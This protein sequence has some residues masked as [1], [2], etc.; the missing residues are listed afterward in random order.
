MKITTRLQLSTMMLLQYFI[1]GAWYVTMSTFL[2][3]TLHCTDV[4][5]GSAYGF[6]AL[7]FI[8][9][10]FFTGLVADRFF[11]SEKILGVLHIV[12]AGL[13]YMM[14]QST[15]FDV[16][17]WLLVIY[18]LL[19]APT[20]ALTSSVAM[21]QIANPEKDFPSIR[22]FGTGGWIV[23]GLLISGLSISEAS[24]EP[25]FLAAVA[26]LILGVF[27]FAL[28]KTPPKGKGEKASLGQMLGLDALGMMKD[29]SFATL[30]ISIFLIYIPMTF[31]FQFGNMFMNELGWENSAATQ[32][33]GQVSEVGFMLLLPFFLAR[34][35]LKTMILA[36]MAGWIARYLLFA[37]ADIDAN[38]WMVYGGIALHGVCYDFLFVSTQIYLDKKAPKNLRSSAQALMAT[39]TYGLGMFIG[40]YAA[41]F[42]GRQFTLE[43]NLHEWNPIW[44]IATAGVGVI[45]LIFLFLFKDNSKQTQ[46]SEN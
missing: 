18:M 20:I 25:F 45:A 29:R 39:A 4:E 26:S 23:A 2:S 27:S 14:S 11:D 34:F 31:Y 46:V 42:V 17:F 43:N 36:G 33:L 10:P 8:I 35:G 28:P 9:S 15:S 30:L 6:T 1:W 16:F 22:V 44:L 41:G 40:A 13:L 7:A 37:Y 5:V 32:T 12:G 3:K 24:A 19:Y 38:A 21:Q